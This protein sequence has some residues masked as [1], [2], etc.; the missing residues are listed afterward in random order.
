MTTL[1]V[2]Y[3]RST[4]HVLAAVTRR[5][6]PAADED[7][8]GLVG[9]GLP[10]R[11][12]GL[13]TPPDMITV[14]ADRLATAVVES[15]TVLEAPRQYQVVEVKQNDQKKHELRQFKTGTVSITL[16]ATG[17]KLSYPTPVDTVPHPVLVILEQ[18]GPPK[19][20]S[21]SI[22]AN[23]REV[24]L[25]AT[26]PAGSTWRTL[27]LVSGFELHAEEKTV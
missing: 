14:P 5:E 4:G 11:S 8:A 2:I 12:V 10:L 27:T 1:T 21:G 6:P 3:G 13:L 16:T 26:L 25:L 15:D 20:L 19:I 24:T 17:A 7:P 23:T 9:S 22:P 18:A